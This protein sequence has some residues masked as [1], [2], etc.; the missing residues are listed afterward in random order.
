MSRGG[1]LRRHLRRRGALLRGG[2]RAAGP[3][4]LGRGGEVADKREAVSE[5][6][7]RQLPAADGRRGVQVRH[8][9]AVW[10]RAVGTF[11]R[12][13]QLPLRRHR[14][15][16]REGRLREPPRGGRRGPVLC[17][18]PRRPHATGAS[19]AALPRGRLPH[20]ARR[21][22]RGP[23]AAGRRGRDAGGHAAAGAPHPDALHR[24]HADDRGCLRPTGAGE[25]E[26]PAGGEAALLG[27]RRGRGPGRR[28][29]QRHQRHVPR[30]FLGPYRRR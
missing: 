10:E 1:A 7:Q 22:S 15:Q 19:A 2:L 4:G 3:L 12:E 14:R 21:P 13:P 24:E 11:R 23:E 9:G 30:P 16:P 25:D 8:P 6:G 20:R 26:R 29:R 5:V 27:G 28:R 18:R 17:R